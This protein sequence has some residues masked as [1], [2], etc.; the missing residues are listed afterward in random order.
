MKLY[1]ST[2]SPYVRRIR[3]I[4][5]NTSHEFI[6]LQ[7][8]AGED[9][10]LLASR[11]PTMKV[12]CLEDDGQMLFDSRIIYRYLGEKLGH[13]DLNWEQ[14]NQL[15]LIDAANDS[16]VQ[17]LL[18]NRSDIDTSQDKLH[19]RLQKERI[20]AVLQTLEAQLEQGGFG[21]WAYPEISLYTLIDWVEFRQLHDL[22]DFPE[23]RAF[24]ERHVDRIEVTA[25]DPRQ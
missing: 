7:I 17:L 23:L 13:T 24:R 16:F 21:G 8:F 11:N 18:L 2:T 6:D 4:L 3:I 14:E 22:A 5:A 19:F 15:T 9:R 1:G 12:P 10:K 25:T 20:E